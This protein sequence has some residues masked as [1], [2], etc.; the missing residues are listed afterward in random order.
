M[1]KTTRY[2]TL[3]NA[4]LTSFALACD[5]GNPPSA[6]AASP[7]SAAAAT[8]ASAPH[9]G[10][11]ATPDLVAPPQQGPESQQVGEIYQL[12]AAFHRA[13]TTQDLDLTMSLW[14]PPRPRSPEP[15]RRG[16]E[17]GA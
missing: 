14:D 1:K 8:Q 11:V 4:A 15:A 9:A 2:A 5:R 17:A 7:A 6:P 13:K 10:P 12:Q 16:L 3:I